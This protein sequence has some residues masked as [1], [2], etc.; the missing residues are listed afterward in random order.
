MSSLA[1]MTRSWP[2]GESSSP[3]EKSIALAINCR[4]R[5]LS[6]IIRRFKRQSATGVASYG[7]LQQAAGRTT[8][9]LVSLPQSIY[10]IWPSQESGTAPISDE[11]K[12]HRLP[13][14]VALPHGENN[15]V[16]L[17]GVGEIAMRLD[18]LAKALDEVIEL[19]LEGVMRHVG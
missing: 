18:I 15:L 6:P 5:L 12:P 8:I 11:W 19:A 16:R 10:E 9:P 3:L 4:R 13:G 2:D 17:D 14:R 7:L 1:L